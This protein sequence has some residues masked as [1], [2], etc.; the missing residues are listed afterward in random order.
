MNR[1][2][3]VLITDYA[4]PSLDIERSVLEPAGVELVIAERGDESELAGL[5]ADADAILSCWKPLTPNV[6]DLATRCQLI[7]KF[8]TGIDNIAVEHATKLGIIIA[9]VPDFCL[10]EVSDHALALLLACARRIVPL[11]LE[12]RTG[13]WNPRHAHDLRRIRGRTL[14]VIGYGA[15]ARTLIPKAKAFGMEIVVYTPRIGAGEIEPGVTATN[16]LL[17]ALK[18]AD[19]VTIHAPA[20]DE[21]RNLIDA[22]ALAAMKPTAWLINTSRGALIDEPALINALQT[23]QIA[24]AA[25][26]VLN[27]EPPDADNPLLSMANVLITPHAAFSSRDALEDLQRKAT[28][29]IL[30]LL[31]GEL[32]AN[33][34]NPGVL[35]SDALR[36]R[37][38]P[39][40]S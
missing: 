31:R 1:H 25:L 8:G 26:D 5:V 4:W 22:R 24:G 30:E 35:T 2:P 39:W 21:T 29:R 28:S 19:Y 34:V 33:I 11:V 17:A 10:D 6:L 36:F 3:V 23:G 13:D 18:V 12:T 37:G 20:T 14:T 27:R 40:P 38:E 32:P 15:I 7:S 16:D 9:N